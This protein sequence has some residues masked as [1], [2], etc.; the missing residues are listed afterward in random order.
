MPRPESRAIGDKALTV[1]GM[2]REIAATV[3]TVTSRR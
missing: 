1:P 2:K 3:A